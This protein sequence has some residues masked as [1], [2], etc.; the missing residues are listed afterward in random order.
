M[1]VRSEAAPV[2]PHLTGGWVALLVS[3]G[4]LVSRKLW[5]LKIFLVLLL[6]WEV[7]LNN[8]PV[9][10]YFKNRFLKIQSVFQAVFTSWGWYFGW[11]TQFRSWI[12]QHRG[13]LSDS[14]GVERIGIWFVSLCLVNRQA[15]DSP[16][17]RINISSGKSRVII[18]WL[19]N[20]FSHTALAVPFQSRSQSSG[21][22]E[23]WLGTPQHAFQHFG[24][25]PRFA[26]TGAGRTHWIEKLWGMIM[27]IN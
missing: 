20:L 18:N 22:L 6:S 8:N 13:R 4:V 23:H 2:S 15:G 24:N 17:N 26:G 10:A 1:L 11:L 3:A 5:F 27:I 25:Q 21:Y 9:I 12:H 19:V 14:P 16:K 7:L